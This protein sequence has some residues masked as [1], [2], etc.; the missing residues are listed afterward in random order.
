MAE[1]DERATREG[2]AGEYGKGEGENSTV[3]DKKNSETSMKNS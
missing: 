2:E 1:I 3:S